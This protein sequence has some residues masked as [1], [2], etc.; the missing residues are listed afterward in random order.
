MHIR[1]KGFLLRTP[2]Q[3]GSH[4]ILTWAPSRRWSV[5][6]SGN[7]PKRHIGCW[8]RTA[9]LGFRVPGH[10]SY[11]FFARPSGSELLWTSIPAWKTTPFCFFDNFAQLWQFDFCHV[12]SHFCC[13]SSMVTFYSN[14]VWGQHGIYKRIMCLKHVLVM[15]HSN[16]ATGA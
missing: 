10:W 15:Y 13:I 3:G 11:G 4:W 9:A 12:C 8:K 16:K 5:R 7:L 6:R 1:C 2:S 14:T